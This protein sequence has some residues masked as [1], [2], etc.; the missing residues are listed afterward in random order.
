[1]IAQVT[2][3]HR[4]SQFLLWLGLLVGLL[5]GLAAAAMAIVAAIPA[6]DGRMP[7]R[8]LRL[9]IAIVPLVGLASALVALVPASAGNMSYGA[10]SYAV[11]T[12]LAVI[13]A[14]AARSS[15]R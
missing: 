15:R 10:E 7:N 8:R 4:T 14:V 11:G 9:G 12:A 2:R 1:M 5:A 3:V 13:A 6:I